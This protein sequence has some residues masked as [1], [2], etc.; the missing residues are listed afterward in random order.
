MWKSLKASFESFR[1]IFKGIG[2]AIRSLFNIDV[3]GVIDGLKAVFGGIGDMLSGIGETIAGI[4]T[5]D[6]S[7]LSK[8]FMKFCEGAKNTLLGLGETIAGLFNID[9]SGVWDSFMSGFDSACSYISGKFGELTSWV[10]NGLSSAWNWT[11][12]LF[13]YGE[14]AGTQEQAKLKAQVQDI[15]VLNKMS[16]GFSQ[17][18]AEMTTAWQPFKTSLGEGFEQIYNVMQGIADKVHGVTI[19][20][21]NELASALSKIATEISSIVQAGSLEVE[22]KTQS[23]DT[24]KSYSR[25][26]GSTWRVRKRAKGGSITS[27]EIAL[28]GEAGRE[29]VIPLENKARGIP[30]W[31]AT[32][33]EMGLLFGNTTNNDNRQNSTVFSPSYTITVN[34]GDQNTEQR[35]RQII[36][37]TFCCVKKNTLKRGKTSSSQQ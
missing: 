26:V 9:F 5:F 13:G 31:K 19:Q 3:S 23:T 36:E 11:K 21:V 2:E 7:T 15:T 17:R 18:V 16:E 28:I 4:F 33:E 35:F 30:L 25:T 27:P 12:G 32:G 34:G 10:G 1:G 37:E 24:T 20:A 6:F 22:V 14:E 29:A 8:G